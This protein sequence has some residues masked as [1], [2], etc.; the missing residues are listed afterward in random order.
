MTSQTL[1]SKLSSL[2]FTSQLPQTARE[3]LAGIASERAFGKGE[4]LCREGEG[5]EELF[6]INKGHVG[7]DMLVPGRG[8]VRVMT[9][10]PGDVLAW[11]ALIGNQGATATGVALDDVETVVFPDDALLDLCQVN[12]EVGYPLMRE[13]AKA[14]SRR[15]VA[16][17]LQLLDL[18]RV[19]AN[20]DS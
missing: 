4:V 2:Q 9:L 20:E 10:G 18:F 7:L 12:S 3:A 5:C 13:L 1:N 11:S 15:L 17:R 16:S 6:L 19:G 14:I 8:Q